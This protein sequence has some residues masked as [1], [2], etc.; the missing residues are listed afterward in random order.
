MS[1]TEDTLLVFH[2]LLE[3]MLYDPHHFMKNAGLKLP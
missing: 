3:S 1:V 2:T